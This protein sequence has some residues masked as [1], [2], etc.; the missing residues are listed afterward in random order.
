MG[1]EPLIATR[2]AEPNRELADMTRRF[3]IGAV[4]SLPVIALGMGSEILGLGRVVPAS[5][6]AWLQCAFATPVVL[7]AGLPFFER[8][9]Q[10][11]VTRN[12]NM[13]TLIALGTGVAWTYSVI[14]TAFP[15]L[16]PP[17]LRWGG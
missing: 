12:L 3:W 4:L 1:L 15:Q 10:S 9:W 6:S 7:W 17:A 13:F 2:E 5:V 16:F 14:A 11:L 8:A